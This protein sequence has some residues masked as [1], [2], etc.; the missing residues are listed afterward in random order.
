M[1]MPP[2][3]PLDEQL[4]YGVYA[5]GIAIQRA[6]KPLLDQL[7]L[8]YPQYLVLNLLWARDAQPV[9]RL[10]DQLALESSTLTPLL[11]RLE[12]AGHVRRDRNPANERQV[13]VN[14]T[15]SGRAMRHKAGCLA[16][17]LLEA[18]G[19]SPE[20]LNELNQKVQALRHGIYAAIGGWSAG[21][22]EASND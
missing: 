9:G 21:P 12:V 15:A 5:A 4:C 18:S 6:Y 2:P 1:P 16:A 20:A 3:P 22:P 14:L 8:T 7:G 11:K 10:A 19:Q 13:M 17:A